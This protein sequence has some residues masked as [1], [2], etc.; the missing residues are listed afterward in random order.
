MQIFDNS[1]SC[2]STI[3]KDKKSLSEVLRNNYKTI[4]R[5]ANRTILSIVGLSLRN[6]FLINHFARSILKATTVEEVAAL[7]VLFS[8]IAFN[9]YSNKDEITNDFNAFYKNN[10]IELTEEQ[11]NLIK[12]LLEKKKNFDFKDINKGSFEFFSIKFN[13]PVWLLKMLAHQYDRGMMVN[14]AKACSK[15]P[16]QYALKNSFVE[17]PFDQ[18]AELL[19]DFQFDEKLDLYKYL[20][21]NSLK[22]NPLVK[23]DCLIPVQIASSEL[24]K[25]LP[26]LNNKEVMVFLEH[27]DPIFFGVVMKYAENNKIFLINKYP[28]KTYSLVE[29]IK[30]CPIRQFKNYETDE[31]GITTY[32]DSLQD[33]IIYFPETSSL[34]YVRRRPEYSIIFDTNTLDSLIGNQNK[35]IDELSKHV[36]LDGR[37]IYACNTI[38]IKETVLVVYK[39]LEKHKEFKEEFS[40]SSFPCDPNNSIYYYSILRRIK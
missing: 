17:V 31:T 27:K 19:K 8:T 2:I 20:P 7:G 1:V 33:L 32:V 21:E 15:M 29:K 30:K 14:I 24:L 39:F 18:R 23:S 4:G 34:D 10:G 35:T 3:I 11:N 13:L 6:Y 40:Q 5:E 16:L 37:L 38:N 9:K 22:N 12:I 26:I 25:H 36:E 28:Q